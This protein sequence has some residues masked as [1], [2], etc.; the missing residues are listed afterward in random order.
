MELPSAEIPRILRVTDPLISGLRP[1]QLPTGAH[2]ELRCILQGLGLIQDFVCG[3]DESGGMTSA[4]L[5]WSVGSRGIFNSLMDLSD[6]HLRGVAPGPP[7]A[8]MALP[9]EMRA[10]CVNLLHCWENPSALSH[11]ETWTHFLALKK[12]QLDINLLVFDME[13]TYEDTATKTEDLRAHLHRLLSIDG[14]LVYKM[15]GTGEVHTRGQTLK[16]LGPLFVSSQAVVTSVT[17][18]HSS[19][20]YFVGRRLIRTRIMTSYIMPASLEA[21]ADHIPA[22]HSYKEEFERALKLQ[23]D[24][25]AQGVPHYVIPDPKDEFTDIYTAMGLGT[26]SAADYG[27][28]LKLPKRSGAKPISLVLGALVFLSN[29]IVSLTR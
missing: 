23:P 10:R 6:R 28:S 15:Y 29:S 27:E 17:S 18:F 12:F 16:Q 24:N 26:G 8:V 5:H 1:V 3:G 25:L 21:L 7:S 4:I 9:P 22:S 19:E 13:I 2:Y 11:P 20:F 14:T